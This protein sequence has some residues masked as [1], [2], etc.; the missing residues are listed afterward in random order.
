M[1][2]SIDHV[3][4]L[5]PNPAHHIAHNYYT[6]ELTRPTEMYK[7]TTRLDLTISYSTKC[8]TS[9]KLFKKYQKMHLID[10]KFELYFWFHQIA[11]VSAA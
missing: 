6:P 3:S 1:A 9:M 2:Y 5:F 7:N 10:L 4:L 8:V 11:Y